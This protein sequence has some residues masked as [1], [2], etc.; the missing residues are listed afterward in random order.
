[1]N[2]LI[3]NIIGGLVVNKKWKWVIAIS[4]IMIIGGLGLFGANN[5]QLTN[6]QVNNTSAMIGLDLFGIGIIVLVIGKIGSWFN[7]P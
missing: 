6:A 1:M 3:T 4:W 7:R 2:Q 5:G